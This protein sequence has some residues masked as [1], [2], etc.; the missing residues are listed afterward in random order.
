[1]KFSTESPGGQMIDVSGK[2]DEY[3]IK[4]NFR[5]REQLAFYDALEKLFDEAM[6]RV[7][8]DG[9]ASTIYIRCLMNSIDFMEKVNEIFYD[10]IRGE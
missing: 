7:T 1:M 9:G 2:N 8:Q 3:T 6:Y 5:M 4:C 10:N